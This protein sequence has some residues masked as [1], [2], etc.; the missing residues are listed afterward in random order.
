MDDTTKTVL[1]LGARHALTT[2]AGMLIAHGYLQSSQSQA[3][4]GA[5]ML[6]IGV[7]WSWWQKTGRAALE[8]EV[9][10]LRA[11]KAQTTAKQAQ[12]SAAGAKP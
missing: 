1:A 4:V 5:G 3:F 9:A 6:I 8:G 11:W 2:V 12:A 10:Y 7:A